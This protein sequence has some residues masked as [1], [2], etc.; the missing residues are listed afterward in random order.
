[1][2]TKKQIW[3]RTT[4]YIDKKWTKEIN[5]DDQIPKKNKI[6][7]KKNK[8]NVSFDTTVKVTLIPEIQEY[9]DAKL[10]ENMWYSSNDLELFRQSRI[11]ELNEEKYA[12]M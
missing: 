3:R 4:S 5:I 11:Q 7:P 9:V 2:L 10:A 12:T 1:M 6:I 8:I